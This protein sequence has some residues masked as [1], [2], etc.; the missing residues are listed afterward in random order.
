MQHNFPHS[1]KKIRQN[2]PHFKIQASPW[3]IA[4]ALN[5]KSFY[6]QTILFWVFPINH[7]TFGHLVLLHFE[8]KS[9]HLIS[10]VLFMQKCYHH[11]HVIRVQESR[12]FQYFT[13][14]P[15]LVTYSSTL[16]CYWKNYLTQWIPNRGRFF[17]L[18][19]L[20]PNLPCI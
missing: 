20:H 5:S 6:I 1:C 9:M 16:F 12:I 3:A 19:T 2:W 15:L 18:C 7:K 11:F 10:L 17:F 8:N 4:T 13:D 14:A